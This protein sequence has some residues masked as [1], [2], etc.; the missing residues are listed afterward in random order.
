[1]S[2]KAQKRAEKEALEKAEE[3][4]LTALLFGGGAVNNDADS[5]GSV[6]SESDKEESFEMESNYI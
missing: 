3:E 6:D 2:K 5:V 4:R 1:M